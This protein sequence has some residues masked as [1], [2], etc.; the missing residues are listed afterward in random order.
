[1][2]LAAVGAALGVVMLRPRMDQVSLWEAVLPPEVLRL[3]AVLARVDALLDDPVFFTPVRAVLRPK[4]R[5]PSTP[6]DRPTCG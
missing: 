2:V 4:G 1:M 6:M 5:A 3:P